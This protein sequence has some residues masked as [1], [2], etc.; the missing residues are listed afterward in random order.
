PGTGGRGNA[1]G[2]TPTVKACGASPRTGAD[3]RG[4]AL[5]PAAGC[6]GDR[7]GAWE[8]DAEDL[9]GARV[10]EEEGRTGGARTM[11]GRGMVGVIVGG[12]MDGPAL[13]A[14]E[15]RP[16]RTPMQRPPSTTIRVSDGRVLSR[17]A[18]AWAT[19]AALAA[20]SWNKSSSR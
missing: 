17:S 7:G 8:G 14:C 20:F 6:V 10:G 1:A 18:E 11:L 4:Q 9:G 13:A 3:K 16:M 2:P 15:V 12:A 5:K 19:G